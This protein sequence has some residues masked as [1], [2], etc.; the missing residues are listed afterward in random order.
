MPHGINIQCIRTLAL[1]VVYFFLHLF[2]FFLD[3]SFRTEH[4]W[5]Y[6]LVAALF[7][8]LLDFL[9]LGEAKD[10]DCLV[11]HSHQLEPLSKVELFQN[12]KLVD[13]QL[14]ANFLPVLIEVGFTKIHEFDS[15]FNESIVPTHYL[16]LFA[17][18]K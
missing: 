8:S 2:Q 10:V 6:L 9:P 14:A 5:L 4:T 17:V 1:L 13:I 3:K 7:Q 11:I 12:I 15:I 16:T 18:F